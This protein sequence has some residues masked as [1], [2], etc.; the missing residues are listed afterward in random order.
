MRGGPLKLP[1]LVQ[2]RNY[3]I[4]NYNDLKRVRHYITILGVCKVIGISYNR[5]LNFNSIIAGSSLGVIRLN[6][7]KL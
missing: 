6:A 7:L 3:K 4:S 1:D 5:R 2:G